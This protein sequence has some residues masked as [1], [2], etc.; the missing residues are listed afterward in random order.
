VSVG[1]NF[2]SKGQVTHPPI[3]LPGQVATA[4][5]IHFDQRSAR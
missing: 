2:E 5:F 1:I 4:N 3:G